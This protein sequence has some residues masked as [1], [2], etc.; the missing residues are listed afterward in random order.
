MRRYVARRGV[1]DADVITPFG[2]FRM[3]VGGSDWRAE[4]G[5]PP[6]P[7]LNPRVLVGRIAIDGLNDP[8]SRDP[9]RAVFGGLVFLHVA[10]TGVYQAS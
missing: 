5:S 9:R 10:S 3:S 8:Q 1:K 7:G 6:R 4:T 2:L